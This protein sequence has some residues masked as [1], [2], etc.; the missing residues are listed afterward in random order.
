MAS[1]HLLCD[2]DLKCI[3]LQGRWPREGK[4]SAGAR[5]GRARSECHSPGKSRIGGL[6][7]F[8]GV[9]ADEMAGQS[10]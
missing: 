6:S 5:H 10:T 8:F 4:L 3:A 2:Q 7:S 1:E 9:G